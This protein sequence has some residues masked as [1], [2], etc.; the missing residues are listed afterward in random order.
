MTYDEE[1]RATH[2]L[3]EVEQEWRQASEAHSVIGTVHEAS[4]VIREEFEEFWDE[5]KSRAHNRALI[6]RELMQVAA[7]CLRSVID[8][9][10]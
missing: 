6:R 7:M 9:K 4:A 5:V 2:F 8:L 1:T 10:L 3:R